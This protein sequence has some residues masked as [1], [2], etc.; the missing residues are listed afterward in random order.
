MEIR[1]GIIR[2]FNSGTYLADVQIVGSVATVLTGV[3]V[4]KE[5]RADLL[6]SGTKCGVLFF[7]ETNPAD[8]CVAFIYDGAPIHPCARVSNTAD[9]SI[10]HATLTA[11]AFDTERFDTDGIHDTV[12]NNSRLTCKTAGKYQ[13]TAQVRWQ[14][15]ATGY[16]EIRIRLNGTTQICIVRQGAHGLDM[17]VVTTLYDLG[18]DDYVEVM[19]YQNSGGALNVEKVAQYSPEFMMVK[20]A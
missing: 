17:Q 20:V 9:Q 5:I 16:R 14:S 13:I 10:P 6:T 8:G 7:D 19:V 3:P 1:R 18:V 15:N 2:A 11:L 12:T 4:A